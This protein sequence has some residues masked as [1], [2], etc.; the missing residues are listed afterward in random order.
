MAGRATVAVSELGWG[1][2]LAY[3]MIQP[4]GVS[5]SLRLRVAYSVSPQALRGTATPP[6]RNISASTLKMSGTFILRFARSSI[7][8]I[9]VIV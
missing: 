7:T 5:R 9:L 3:P 1:D 6:L 2:V 8:A 4:L